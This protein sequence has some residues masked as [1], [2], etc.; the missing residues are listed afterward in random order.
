MKKSSIILVFIILVV[1]VLG[2]WIYSANNNTYVGSNAG[3][4]Y[5]NTTAYVAPTSTQTSTPVATTQNAQ[6][7]ADSPLAQNAYLISIPT[8]TYDANTKLAL[9]GFKV[10]QKTLADGSVQITL[11]AQKTGYQTQTYT[12]KSGEKLY[13]IEKNLTDDD[14]TTDTDKFAGDDQAV[15]VDANGYILTQ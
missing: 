7:F 3:N 11:D 2:I 8:S 15:L 12:V 14:K 4:G 9:S 6:L 5:N 10:T 13:F 1:I